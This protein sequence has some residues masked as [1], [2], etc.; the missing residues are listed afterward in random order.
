MAV[1]VSESSSEPVFV[2][3]IREPFRNQY[4]RL[5]VEKEIGMSVFFLRELGIHI[6]IVSLGLDHADQVIGRDRKAEAASVEIHEVNDDPFAPVI[7]LLRLEVE[8][9]DRASERIAKQLHFRL[10]VGLTPSALRNAR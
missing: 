3:R 8:T 7:K 1:L 4:P 5:S 10:P 9:L 2:A 6:E